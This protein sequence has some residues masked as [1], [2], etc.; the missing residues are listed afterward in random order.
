MDAVR[1]EV[2]VRGAVQG[3]G[4][5][6]WT[7]RRARDLGL[8][9]SVR[10]RGDGVEVALEGPVAAVDR[11]LAD[12]ADAPPR[13]ARIE[14]VTVRRG[15]ARGLLGFA[16]DASAEAAETA[17]PRVPLDAPLCGA[18]RDELFDAGG[19][20]HRYAF[21]HCASCGPR[22]AVL[23]ALPWDRER[24]SLAGFPPCPACRAE[25]EDPKDRRHHA[26]SIAC[27]ACG[28]CLVARSPDGRLLD[29]DPVEHAAAALRAGAVVAL[30]GTGGFHLAVDARQDAAVARLRARKG[31]PCKP[32][33]V[34]VADLATARRLAVLDAED[35]ALLAGP[36]HAV[37]TAPRRS[38]RRPLAPSVAPGLTDLGL[39]LPYAPLQ[40]L[41]LYAP[42]TAPPDDAPRFEALV[43]TSANPSGEPT[44]HRDEEAREALSPVA[45]LLLEHDRPVLR[46]N[47]DPVF[48]SAP[49]GA[50]PLRLSRGTA[51]CLLRL[52]DGLR[53][54]EPVA[55]L[56]GDLKC[57]PA[58]AWGGEVLLAEHVGDLASA[59]AAEAASARLADLA[60]LA[61]ATPVR[62]AHDL[63]PDQV[64]TR[65]AAGL[66]PRRVAV[67]HHHA[68]AAAALVEH[69]RSGPVLALAL[70]GL[71]LGPDGTA[72]GGELLHVDL[73]RCRRLA[74]LE[75]VPLAGGDAA[76]REPWR[77]AAVWL[78][79]AF[80]S[81]DAPRLAWHGR[82]DPA[83]TA[84][85]LAAA[86]RGHAGPLTSSCGRLF[87]AVASLLDLADEATHEAEAALALEST[88]DRAGRPAAAPAW[89]D[90]AGSERCAAPHRDPPPT[91]LAMAPLV[92]ALVRA[93]AAGAPAPDLAAAFHEALAARLA[94][95]AIGWARPLALRAVVLTGGC[96][97]NRRLLEGVRRR[98]LAA[99]LEPL[100]HRRLPPGDGALAVGQV[101]VA[102]ARAA[103]GSDV[104]RS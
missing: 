95:A 80:P 62:V 4:F 102:V 94:D 8:A 65:L 11:F 98:L 40:W 76:V 47:D 100:V 32:F 44:L 25:Y 59:A 87:D 48:R 15:K 1:A 26:E 12:L 91:V 75:T 30:K 7:A 38:P 31:R 53:A 63:H 33:A 85:L 68:H 54:E 45:D 18:C 83:R 74:H 103:A 28:P 82:R 22:A 52:P 88:A 24:S 5:R 60:R 36:V 3:V 72:W 39:L 20:R 81:G 43:Y 41:L 57:A 23:S 42:G 90:A 69:G 96:F 21:T 99:D 56:G 9:G 6:P 79:R 46:P 50:I 101:A 58:L 77:M 55:A 78:A 67:Q 13:G 19:R 51:P 66:A 34:L 17:L 104:S 93:R 35:E 61:G 10:N 64:A 84:A 16:V 71:G 97:Q 37:V 89:L 92:R 2:H 29:G 86:A 49:S 14:T 27:P 73:V 70:D